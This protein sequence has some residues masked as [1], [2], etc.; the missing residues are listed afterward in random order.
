MA[1][2]QFI[3]NL[4]GEQRRRAIGG[5]MTYIERE[6]YPALN[7]K[8]QRDLRGR[9]IAVV[10]QYHDTCLDVLKAS[11]DDG[12]LVNTEALAVL[13]RMEGKLNAVLS[14]RV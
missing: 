3:R 10:T 5:L 6:V 7:P 2:N 13:T 14:E 12:S 4:M 11:V 1:A 9:V 8:Q